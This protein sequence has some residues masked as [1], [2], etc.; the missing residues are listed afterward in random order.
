MTTTTAS[1]PGK[2][3][4]FGEY[5]VLDGATAGSMALNRRAAVTLRAHDADHSV[6]ESP[7]YLDG[8][9]RFRVESGAVSW[10]DPPPSP[11]AFGILEAAWRRFPQAEQVSITLD[12]RAFRDKD[13]GEKLGLGSSAA[14][15]TAL[16]AALDRHASVGGAELQHLAHDVHTD[17]QHG[18]GSGIDVATSF[19]GGVIAYRRGE[20]AT[21]LSWP[22][23]LSYQFYWSG[24]SAATVTQLASYRQRAVT[25][26]DGALMTSTAAVLEA[27]QEGAVDRLLQAFARYADALAAFD[28]AHGLGIFGAGHDRL[29]EIARAIPG[30]VYKPCGA[31]GGD[32]GI[33]L[34]AGASALEDF[35]RAMQGQGFRPVAA[36]LDMDGVTVRV[37]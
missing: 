7:G 13:S 14:L 11:D 17:F 4:L 28:R 29:A 35:E 25:Q 36:A 34:A 30:C 22:E 33:A 1:A 18:S 21:A 15:V 27:F 24:V 20:A 3:V 10:I 5:V 16:I 37:D 8:K 23:G 19:H 2:A 32:V 6:V 31:G 26:A 9:F 12:T